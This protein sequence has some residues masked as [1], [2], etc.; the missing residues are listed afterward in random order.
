M[1][2]YLRDVLA[3]LEGL[4]SGLNPDLEEVRAARRLVTRLMAS[5]DLRKRPLTYRHALAN[6]RDLTHRLRALHGLTQPKGKTHDHR[7]P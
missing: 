3:D 2:D 1:T 7:R 6:A 5:P 4:A